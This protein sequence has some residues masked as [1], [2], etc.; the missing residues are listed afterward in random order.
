MLSLWFVL[1]I[2]AAQR[3]QQSP[4]HVISSSPVRVRSRLNREMM[5]IMKIMGSL[6]AGG[7]FAQ[8]AQSCPGQ[9]VRKKH[10][11]LPHHH[12]GL[13]PGNGPTNLKKN[14]NLFGFTTKA[15]QRTTMPR[16]DFTDT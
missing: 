7:G 2:A 16:L 11:S 13:G 14:T 6:L 5:G 9:G 15:H 1:L 10:S 3:A 8:S 12:P 4:L